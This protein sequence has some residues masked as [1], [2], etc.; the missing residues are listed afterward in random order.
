MSFVR[1]TFRVLRRTLW[2]L[3]WV[4]LALLVFVLAGGLG[5]TVRYVGPSVA[6]MF[7]LD[8]KVERC[9]ILP[10]GGYVLIEGLQVENP[11]AFSDDKPK[12]YRDEPLVR[13]GRL[14]LDVG[15][16]SLLAK[17]YVVDTLRVEGIR[18]LYAFDFETTNVDALL[19]Q[20]GVTGG[21]AETPAVVGQEPPAEEKKE[22]EAPAG[23]GKKELRFRVGYLNFS[24]NV[25]TVRK[26]V[27]VPI[28]LPALTLHDVDNE[29]LKARVDTLLEPVYKSIRAFGEGLG[30][31]TEALGEG[32]NVLKEGASAA[33][34]ALG[35]GASAVEGL[36]GEG[37]DLS[38]EGIAAGVEGLK[39][40]A[41]SLKDVG[42]GL[43]ES[44]KDVKGDAK[45]TLEGLKGL[46]KKDK[47]KD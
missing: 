20:M 9:V 25:V 11:K 15:V 14:E 6:K 29:T 42:D 19:A 41:G 35:K 47:K 40:A 7:G 16:R 31:A 1:K 38:A 24:D 30:A 17:E 2:V 21:K 44:L 22:G 28:P 43:S 12:L 10:L 39:D 26:Y 34:E 46:F 3:F 8:L 32:A 36:V 33:G 45:E 13:V 5:P 23:E 18:A 4:I 27:S 37:A